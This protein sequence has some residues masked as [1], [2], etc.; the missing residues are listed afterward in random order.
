MHETLENRMHRITRLLTCEVEA[1]GRRPATRRVR[2]VSGAKQDGV[3]Q[4]RRRRRVLAPRVC[5]V[6]GE[7]KGE[8]SGEKEERQTTVCPRSSLLRRRRGQGRRRDWWRRGVEAGE[9][10][11]GFLLCV[12]TFR[13]PGLRQR[14]PMFLFHQESLLIVYFLPYP[15][16]STFIRYF[17]LLHLHLE[18]FLI[19][20]FH[21]HP[22]TSY[23][24]GR[25]FAR[26]GRWKYQTFV[27]PKKCPSFI[28]FSCRRN[29]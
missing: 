29:T 22:S 5:G 6:G 14:L 11:G 21:S 4:A 24:D 9:I 12:I 19:L 10:G 28:L 18:S 27:A 17:S 7:R 8:R 2:N 16:T 26:D 3:E 23:C 25:G 1:A 15:S 13:E 20:Y